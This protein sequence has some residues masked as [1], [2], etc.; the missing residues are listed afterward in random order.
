MK[1]LDGNI[2]APEGA[3]QVAREHLADE[4]YLRR[5]GWDVADHLVVR[6]ESHVP[7]VHTEEVAPNICVVSPVV[8]TGR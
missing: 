4:Y 2:S 5:L 7:R 1:N 8:P 3:S 6:E